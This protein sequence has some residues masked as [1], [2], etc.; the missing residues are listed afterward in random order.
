MPPEDKNA[1]LFPRRING[2]WILLHRPVTFRAGPRAEI[3]LS[4]SRDLDSWRQPERVMLAR[5]GAWWDSTRIGIGPPPIETPHGWLLIYHGVR[6]TLNGSVYRVGAALLDLDDPTKVLYRTPTWLLA[7]TAPYERVGD[8]P[9]VVFPCGTTYEPT[10]DALNLYYGAGDI[11][12]ALATA[13]LGELV[14]Y[15]RAVG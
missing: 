5:E 15:L 7:P 13:Q 11:A 3:W 12:I 8:V 2:D 14:E 6:N 4:R 1:D 9:N 10:T